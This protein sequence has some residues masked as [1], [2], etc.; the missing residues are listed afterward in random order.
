M[1]VF[2]DTEFTDLSKHPAFISV[3][4]VSEDGKCSFY[5][6]LIN[7]FSNESCSDFVHKNV[8]PLL[9][10]DLLSDNFDSKNIYAKM[11][12]AQCRTYLSFWIS[13]FAE[14]V[15]I[16]SDAPYYDWVLIHELFCV[17]FW[18][19]NLLGLPKWIFSGD[20]NEIDRYK[21]MR[22]VLYAT[23]EYSR[24]HALHD[25][26]VSQQAF[27]SIKTNHIDS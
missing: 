26:R 18:P 14:P 15:Q 19:A 17:D 6:E 25:A 16:W 4:L 20:Q 12:I 11:T 27:V 5:A 7:N 23:G 8:L 2:I 21:N 3:G 13:L 1:N 24:H 10:A 22:E 9:D